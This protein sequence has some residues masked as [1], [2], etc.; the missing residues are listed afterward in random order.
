ME[1]FLMNYYERIQKSIEYI[2]SNLENKIDLNQAAREAFMSQSNYYRM[3]FALVG[4][5]MKEYVRPQR[6]SLA[7]SDLVNRHIKVIDI[8]VK[9][10]NWISKSSKYSFGNRWFFE[11]Y[12][13]DKPVIE[14]DTDMVL[15]MPVKLRA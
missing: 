8:A 7:A 9:F 13:I 6:I 11:E 15:H 5:S 4:F 2:E 14:M 10:I 3:F 1:R 12:K